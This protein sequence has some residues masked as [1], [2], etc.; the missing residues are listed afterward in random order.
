[1][2]CEGEDGTC[3]MGDVQKNVSGKMRGC[4]KRPRNRLLRGFLTSDSIS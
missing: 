1:M 2:W 3:L 4:E